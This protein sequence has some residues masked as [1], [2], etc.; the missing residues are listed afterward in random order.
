L[1]NKPTQQKIALLFT[2][3]NSLSSPSSE[4]QDNKPSC[5]ISGFR[6]EVDEICALLGYYTVHSVNFLPTFRDNLSVPS[7]QV[8]DGTDRLSRKVGKELTVFAV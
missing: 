5:V 4:R 1:N 6:R 3:D 7:S 2:D 8:Q